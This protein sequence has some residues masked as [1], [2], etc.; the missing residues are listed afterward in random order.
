MVTGVMKVILVLDYSRGT[1]ID[2]AFPVIDY[3]IAPESKIY[4]SHML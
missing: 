2:A 3:F 4:S 1:L